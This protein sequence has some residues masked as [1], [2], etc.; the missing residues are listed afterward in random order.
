MKVVL[1]DIDASSL[2]LL[3]GFVYTTKLEI[4]ES[5]AQGLLSTASLLGLPDVVAV[6]ARYISKHIT[7]TNC[8][9]GFEVCSIVQSQRS[10]FSCK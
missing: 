6:C 5:N 1:R 4:T 7:P 2:K 10:R 3:V 9:W 8:L